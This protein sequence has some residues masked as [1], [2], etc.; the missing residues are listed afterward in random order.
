MNPDSWI[1]KN[2]RI[3]APIIATL[4]SVGVW[5]ASLYT[6]SDLI[7]LI[8]VVIFFVFHFTGLWRIK[9]RLLGGA[10]VLVAFMLIIGG[11][12]TGVTVSAHPVLTYDMVHGTSKSNTNATVSVTPFSSQKGPYQYD[13]IIN[14]SDIASLNFTTLSVNIT[15]SGNSTAYKI[16]TYSEMSPMKNISNSTKEFSFN[17]SS[18]PAGIYGYNVS[19]RNSTTVIYTTPVEGPLTASPYSIY[20]LVVIS[21]YLIAVLILYVIFAVGVFLA[22]S[23][24]KS[25]TPPQQT[26]PP[27][28]PPYSPPPL[29]PPSNQ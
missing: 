8:P 21:D 1:V 9:L 19:I 7:F 26:P 15:A 25:R 4:A 2:N 29:Q 24:S 5:Y 12:V 6:I 13:I 14:S 18:F 17:V 16:V 10:I 28:Q 22:R 11:I 20:A 3:S 27:N 23:I